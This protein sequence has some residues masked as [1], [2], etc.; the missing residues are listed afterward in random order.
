MGD[1]TVPSP[2]KIYLHISRQESF[3]LSFQL[4]TTYIVAQQLKD[5]QRPI[6]VKS[7]NPEGCAKDET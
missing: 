6:P 5:N 7:N 2:D 4:S 3:H 1:S